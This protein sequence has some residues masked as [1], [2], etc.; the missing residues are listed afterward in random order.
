MNVLYWF[1]ATYFSLQLFSAPDAGSLLNLEKEMQQNKVLPQVIP[2][3]ILSD[4]TVDRD[5]DKSGEKIYVKKFE[6][7][8]DTWF[9]NSKTLNK[10][11][12]EFENKELTF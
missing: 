6:F 8:G 1:L 5:V 11:T 10:L 2:K 4:M 9:L 7:S 12:T 3:S